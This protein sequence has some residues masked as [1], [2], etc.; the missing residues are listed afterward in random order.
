MFNILLLLLR[1]ICLQTFLLQG[2]LPKLLLEKTIR[3]KLRCRPTTLNMSE[4]LNH[5]VSKQSENMART[6]ISRTQSHDEIEMRLS[7][8]KGTVEMIRN[9]ILL[10]SQKYMKSKASHFCMESKTSFV[11]RARHR[12]GTTA[13]V[14]VL[15]YKVL[16]I[17]CRHSPG[18]HLSLSIPHLC[19]FV[20][21]VGNTKE[22][23]R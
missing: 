1:R 3:V 22:L 4:L 23:C 7:G 17:R 15:T 2:I 10:E 6:P 19:L 8:V 18:V 20:F 13:Y 11:T 9:L 12:T 14:N 21:V 16:M 5:F